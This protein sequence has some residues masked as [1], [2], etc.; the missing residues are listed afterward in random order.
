MMI[1]VK[2]VQGQAGGGRDAVELW[3]KRA[4]EINPDNADAYQR[5]FDY[6]RGHEGREA[7][8]AFG[9]ECLATQNWRGGLPFVLSNA[10]E[11]Y[12]SGNKNYMWQGDNWK[13]VEDVYEGSF[14]S[15][16]N[17]LEHRNHYIYLALVARKYDVATRQIQ[18]LGDKSEWY[19]DPA[20]HSWGDAAYRREHSKPGAPK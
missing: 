3:F 20:A 12:S 2:Q 10:H 11:M 6:L 9:H 19:Y 7:T 8:I 5:K 16:P 18:I 17:D 14:L 4:I 13:D 1:S 15:F